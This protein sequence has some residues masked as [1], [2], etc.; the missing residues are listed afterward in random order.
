MDTGELLVTSIRQDACPSTHI[1]DPRVIYCKTVCTSLCS[2]QLNII[3]IHT[4][5]GETVM[6]SDF[7][8]L[9][10]DVTHRNDG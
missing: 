2:V 9:Q 8:R 4:N 5:I 3:L 7:V 1:S 6:F 10:F